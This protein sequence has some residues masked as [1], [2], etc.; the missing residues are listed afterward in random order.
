MNEKGEL[1]RTVTCVKLRIRQALVSHG[2]LAFIFCSRS[3]LAFPIFLL[4][5]R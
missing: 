3:D 2:R 1:E 4:K 5:N